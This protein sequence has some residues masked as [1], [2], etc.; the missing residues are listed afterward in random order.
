MPGSFL[1]GLSLYAYG[2]AYVAVPVFLVLCL[3]YAIV[4]RAWKRPMMAWS[5]GVFV[6]TA[7]PVGL[8]LLINKLQLSSIVTPFFSIP[9]L[10]GVPRYETM[11]NTNVFS[12]EFYVTAWENLSNAFGL[13]SS[14]FDGLPWNGIPE[15]GMI[16][17]F[18]LPVAALG[19]GIL[20]DR[21][22]KRGYHAGFVLL[23]WCIACLVLAAF[24][25]V[26]INRF[27]IVF[28]P[29]AFCTALG[30]SFLRTQRWVFWPLCAAYAVSFVSFLGA[31]FGPY[32]RQVADPFFASFGDAIQ[33]AAAS[34]DGPICVT[35]H[36][37]MPYIFVL[38]F[39]KED[40]RVFRDTVRY[41]NPGA[42]FQGVGAYGRYRFGLNR[43][44]GDTDVIIAK[45][46]ELGSFSDD[47]FIKRSYPLYTVLVRKN[48]RP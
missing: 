29:L 39:T 33:D 28:F 3:L 31:Y 13:L 10:T 47:E 16:Y 46:D 17:L 6:V 34:T 9:R 23:A 12:A 8:F 15:Y 21:T 42:E 11:G 4:H 19:L 35:D 27:N 22:F 1:F 30:I 40:P 45:N 32:E 7:I 14:Q 20:V 36:V 24:V 18:S 48:A 5:A 37:N 38:F 44:A 26:N 43:C 41:D 25:S 2:T